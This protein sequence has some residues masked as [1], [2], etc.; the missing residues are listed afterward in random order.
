MYSSPGHISSQH[1]GFRFVSLPGFAIVLGC[2]D[3]GANFATLRRRML[4]TLAIFAFFRFALF[5]MSLRA[6][7][8]V[9]PGFFP[10]AL[11]DDPYLLGAHFA[12]V[13]SGVCWFLLFSTGCRGLTMLAKLIG[14]GPKVR[15]RLDMHNLWPRHCPCSHLVNI[16][17]VFLTAITS[18]P[19]LQAMLTLSSAVHLA[20]GYG[21]V[22]WP[23]SRA[24]FEEHVAG[25]WTF[26]MSDTLGLQVHG[27][28]GFWPY[29][30]AAL[31]VLGPSFPSQGVG[32]AMLDG[33]GPRA[34]T[35]SSQSETIPLVGDVEGGSVM[36]VAPLWSRL[37][38]PL[39]LGASVLIHALCAH[40]VVFNAWAPLG[41]RW[42]QA[43]GGWQYMYADGSLEHAS[44]LYFIAASL[45][46]LG[47]AAASAMTIT[48]QS[49]FRG[50]LA[51]RWGSVP[52]ISVRQWTITAYRLA[53]V[54]LSFCWSSTVLDAQWSRL[55][56]ITMEVSY[57]YAYASYACS[58]RPSAYHHVP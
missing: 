23:F 7:K 27:L 51:H 45:L 28:A 34:H 57:A 24:Y 17:R 26:M 50:H 49:A 33:A 18:S 47:C 42:R 13:T 48:W 40:L 4:V 58:R 10:D 53:L 19:L 30:T 9:V 44:R 36:T 14:I 56:F 22:G 1:T 3:A 12:A 6:H 31:A 35:T 55:G 39:R 16:M 25:T 52:L 41:W 21:L 43:S 37:G 11:G 54:F 38:T 29:Y 5:P 32:A 2:S 8:Q 15:N 20:S 46:L